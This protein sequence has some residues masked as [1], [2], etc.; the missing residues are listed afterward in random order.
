MDLDSLASIA[1]E[2]SDISSDSA[3]QSHVSSAIASKPKGVTPEFLSKLWMIS[4]PLAQ[5]AID[6][7]T[8]L[9]RYNA[10]NSLS[11]HLSTNDRML[12]Y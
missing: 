6:Q 11:R 1:Q 12:R 10:E 5:A 8:Q 4:E 2:C 7:N 3:F 9:C